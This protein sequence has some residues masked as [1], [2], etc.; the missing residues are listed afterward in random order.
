[1]HKKILIITDNLRDQ[2]N[3]VVTTFKN[4]ESLAVRSGYSLV[5]IDPGQ[6]PHINCPGYPEVKLS[7][8]WGIGKK[9]A[10]VAPD[11]IHI[12]TEGPLGLAARIWCDRNGKTY[13]TSYH[14]KFPEFLERLYNFPRS[15]SYWYMRWFHK[16]SGK[17]LTTTQTMV[18][19]L[20]SH[21]F[22]DNVVSWTRGVDKKVFS[23]KLRSPEVNG[24]PILLSV[25]RVSREKGLDDFC[26]L[27]VPNATKVIVGNGPYRAEL[28]KKYPN[29]MFAGS[30]FEHE[31]AEYYA[32][33][34]VFVFT[35]RVD[36][37]G[38]VMIESLSCGTPVAAY[39]VPGPI[40]IVENGVN[41]YLSDDLNQAIQQC[42]TISRKQV[43][44]SSQKWTWENCWQI[45]HDNLV[46]S[47]F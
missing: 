18:R 46:P 43:Y 13:N 44:K 37:F 4:L 20:K 41:G 2:V 30:K 14:T 15:W 31:L 38:I 3:G 1:M 35:S 28:E 29:V 11:H 34:D 8:P 40:D 23:D 5:Y 12:A 27:D 42:L 10:A 6:F 19:E 39:P 33:A 16:H 32:N 36:T 17:V 47:K 22:S 9:I 24:H 25:G 21:G 45:F 26:Q 7:W